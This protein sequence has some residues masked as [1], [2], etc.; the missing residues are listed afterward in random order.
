MRPGL[1]NWLRVATLSLLCGSVASCDRSKPVAAPE[2]VPAPVATSATDAARPIPRRS[3]P[4]IIITNAPPQIEQSAALS[5]NAAPVI[6]CGAPQTLPCSSPDGVQITLTA[7]VEDVNGTALSVVWNV[8]GKDRYTQQVPAGGPPTSADLTFLYMATPGDHAA[9]V[10]VLDGS[11]SATCEMTVTV[12]KDTQEPVITCPSAISLPVTAGQCSAVATYS[13]KATDNCPDV[14]VTC[15]PP[16]GTAFPIGVSTVVCSAVDAAGNVSECAFD[17]EVHITNRCPKTEVFWRQ[18]PGAWPVNSLQL[19][20]QVYTRSQLLPLL[21]APVTADAS[22][23]LA[24]QLIAASL[25]TAAGADPRPVC[26]ELG[27]ANAVLSAFSGKLP[28]RVS[29]SSGGG[30]RM[31]ELSTRLSA[32]NSGLVTVSCDP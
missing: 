8:D 29:V 10:T 19:G 20:N 26:A 27:Q 2:S 31:I 6:T 7:H 1:K 23:A 14:F 5:T 17:V 30:R 15:D 11:L 21:R 24:R 28:Y 4:I 25:N 32:Y 18:N 22:I 13:P 3:Q 16:S 12:Q 9:K